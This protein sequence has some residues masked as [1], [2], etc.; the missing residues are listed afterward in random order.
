[1]YI[2]ACIFFMP[3]TFVIGFYLQTA[4]K[5]TKFRSFLLEIPWKERHAWSRWKKIALVWHFQ[6]KISIEHIRTANLCNDNYLIIDY[7]N[8]ALFMG[9]VVGK[10]CINCPS[11]ECNNQ[12]QKE[13]YC[14]HG[15]S[16]AK[17]KLLA[18]YFCCEA[19]KTR[20]LSFTSY[21][22][23][24]FKWYAKTRWN[25]T[26]VPSKMLTILNSTQLDVVIHRVKMKTFVI[27]TTFVR[28]AFFLVVNVVPHALFST[29]FLKQSACFFGSPFHLFLFHFNETHSF[30]VW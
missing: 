2:L 27:C 28:C 10:L 15:K 22:A 14:A 21:G 13:T 5:K 8:A 25:T 4:A 26:S 18:T 19:Q 3:D 17:K 9:C 23:P 6:H 11:N 1:M 30:M 24:H 7:I 20:L 16:N 29:Y 12:K